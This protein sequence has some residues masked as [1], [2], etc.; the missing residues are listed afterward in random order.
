MNTEQNP[1]SPAVPDEVALALHAMND[2]LCDF[3]NRWKSDGDYLRCVKCRRPIIAS[4]AAQAFQHAA[5]CPS[6]LLTETHPWLKL[7]ELLRPLWS[8]LSAA[9]QA[10]APEPSDAMDA[11]AANSLAWA[12]SRWKDEVSLRPLVNVHRRTL[13]DTWRQVIRHFGGD[14]AKLLGPNHDTLLMQ[15]QEARAWKP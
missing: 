14:P 11:H 15:E 6:R 1:A 4:A 2:A 9:P 7:L 8:Q 5:D 3:S 12:V 13:D 10:P